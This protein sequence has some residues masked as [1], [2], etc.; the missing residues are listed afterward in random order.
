[1]QVFIVYLNTNI[2]S[3]DP[4]IKGAGILMIYRFNPTMLLSTC[5]K[6]GSGFPSPYVVIFFGFD[7]LR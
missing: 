1:M 7:D 3:G 4:I 2:T 6:P 5:P